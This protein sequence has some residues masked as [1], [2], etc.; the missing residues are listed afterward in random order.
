MI[1]RE[2]RV[3]LKSFILWNIL[4][5]GL[6]MIVYMIY[7]TMMSG[8][9]AKMLNEIL[10]AF[11]QE[12]LIA[13]NMDISTIDSAFGWLKGE[14]FIF[15]LLIIGCYSGIM[16][17]H[18]VLKEESDKTIEYLHTLPIKRTN[19]VLNKIFVA[20]FYIVMMVVIL[21]IGNYIGLKYNG[22]F[23]EKQFFLLSVTPLLS[24]L[25]IFGICLLLST[26]T[27]KTKKMIGLS[28][29]I[30]FGSYIIQVIS[31]LSKD[32][33]FLKY[34]SVYT[35]SDIRNV[36]MNTSIDL[37]LILISFIITVTCILFTIIRYNIKELV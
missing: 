35:L 21:T 18:I 9:E 31:S 37:N 6:F 15:I 30:P 4:L 29:A 3:N 1:K 13:F 34:L 7:P 20:L 11:P 10:N 14:G 5:V 2:L 28:L 16:G 36:V 12:L 19:I 33:E 23:D 25:P 17:S 24:S 26:F 27:H 32:V 8:E 22:S